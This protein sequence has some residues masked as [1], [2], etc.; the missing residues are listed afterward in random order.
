LGG[1]SA[2]A[3]ATTPAPDTTAPTTPTGLTATAMSASQVNLGWTASTDNVA[4]TGYILQR[5]QGAGC[6]AWT[7]IATPTATTYSDTGLAAATTYRYW[8][9]AT[10]AAGNLSGWSSI[11]SAA[12]ASN[13]VPD[14]TPPTVSISFPLTGATVSSTTTIT[15]N[16]T[17]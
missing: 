8:V 10:D 15:A 7:T 9:R 17:D 16:A 13:P 1:Y 5:C 14:T 11:V 2:V 6:S 4:V 3:S 12:T